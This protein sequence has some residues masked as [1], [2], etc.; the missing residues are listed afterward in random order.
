[1]LIRDKKTII[2]DKYSILRL[3]NFLMDLSMN[4]NMCGG[5]YSFKLKFSLNIGKVALGQFKP[6]I[7]LHHR[8]TFF[9]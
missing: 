2:F 9:I 6:I 4:E 1:M 8:P 7:L 3:N 5:N